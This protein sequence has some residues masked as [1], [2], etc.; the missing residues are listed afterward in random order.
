MYTNEKRAFFVYQKCECDSS[1]ETR[2]R[3]N[4]RKKLKIRMIAGARPKYARPR[5]L[6]CKVVIFSILACAKKDCSL[7]Q[8][9][10]RP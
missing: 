10:S 9:N 4:L 6:I 7:E 1:F 3:F 2:L 5:S 8:I